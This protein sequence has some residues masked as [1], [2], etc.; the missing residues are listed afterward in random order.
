MRETFHHITRTSED[1]MR[2]AAPAADFQISF[3]YLLFFSVFLK[4]SPF[5]VSFPFAHAHSLLTSRV[6]ASRLCLPCASPERSS[7][8][9]P[10]LLLPPK[11]HVSSPRFFSSSGYGVA[12][13]VCL[14]TAALE[15][16][17][18]SGGRAEENVGGCSLPLEFR[19]GGRENNPLAPDA[20]ASLRVFVL[21][22]EISDAALSACKFTRMKQYKRTLLFFCRPLPRAY[23]ALLFPLPWSEEG[24]RLLQN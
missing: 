22:P 16:L 18:F 6:P 12:A 17:N 5:S 2:S 8:Y 1:L 3:T 4:L 19:A 7:L 14:S 20:A 10:V 15:L 13:L 24:S 23:R 21:L 9:F 11:I